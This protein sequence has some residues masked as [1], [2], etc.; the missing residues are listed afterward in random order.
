MRI[1]F[2]K[3]FLPILCI[4]IGFA[5]M[6]ACSPQTEKPLRI[7]S[8]TWTGYEPMYLA[9]NLSF[10]DD[11][12][13]KLI[14]L[15]SASDVIHALRTGAL[16]GAALTL[17]E[18]LTLIDDGIALKII[19]VF[20][21]SF[22]GDALLSKP[23]ITSIEQLRGKRIAVESSAV[24]ALL[25]D[26][27]LNSVGL[28]ASEIELVSCTLDEHATCYQENHAVV[29]FDP[30]KSKLIRQGANLL[31]DSRKIPDKIVDVLVIRDDIRKTHPNSLKQLLEGYFRARHYFVQHPV[32]AAKLMAPRL[33]LAPKDTLASFEQ[34][35]MPQLKENYTLL[36]GEMSPIT[37]TANELSAFMYNR[38]L[39]RSPLQLKKITDPSFLPEL[40]K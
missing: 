16:E 28:T 5:L 26:S 27:A 21:F 34:L 3:I 17:D 15:T 7:G 13:V 32:E 23:E 24:G 8:N 33:N 14:E 29:T 1:F 39:L 22:G 35:R 11:T 40:T 30:T 6:T 25:L 12:Q 9:R 20:D 4:L 18:T 31:F 10:Y 2:S 36:S 38:K 37:Q 19:L